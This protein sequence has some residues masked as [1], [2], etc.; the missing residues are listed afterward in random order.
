MSRSLRS[1]QAMAVAV[2]LNLC[3]VA[4]CSLWPT[5]DIECIESGRCAAPNS[6]PEVDNAIVFG[7]PDSRT[8]LQ[9]QNGL[10]RPTHAIRVGRRIVI[11]DSL[12]H[13]VVIKQDPSAPIE[14]VAPVVLGQPDL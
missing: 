10:N 4:S 2:S 14:D 1:A 8:N 11:A 5:V 6:T 13:R 9:L 3:G 12:N 7:Q